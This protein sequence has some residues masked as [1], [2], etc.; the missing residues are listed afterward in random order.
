ME[1]DE[2]GRFCKAADKCD[3]DVQQILKEAAPAAARLLAQMLE[4]ADMKREV[5]ID[6]ALR[7]LERVYGKGPQQTEGAEEQGV[8]FV[9]EGELSDYAT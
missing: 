2:K 8:H 7:I 1:R 3:A 9:L 6:C 5:R 4:D